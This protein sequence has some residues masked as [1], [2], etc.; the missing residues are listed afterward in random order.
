MSDIHDIVHGRWLQI[1][2]L[3]GIHLDYLVKG[4]R[5]V[6]NGPCPCCGGKDRF[7]FKIE[8]DG[9]ANFYCRHHG[10]GDGF[11]LLA[12]CF[13]WD[14]HRV[15]TEI[16]DIFG[17][18][19]QRELPKPPV[20]VQDNPQDDEKKRLSMRKAWVG[21]K[22]VVANDCV[23]WYLR[24]RGLILPVVPK[25]LRSHTHMNYYHVEKTLDKLGTY[26]CMLALVQDVEGKP[27]SLHR[28]YLQN[29]RKAKILSRSGE[30]LDVRKAMARLEGGA[31]R[32]FEPVDGMIAIAE[33]IETSL[34]VHLRTGLPVWSA[35]SAPNM[36]KMEL[37]A[38]IRKVIIYGDNDLPDEK[39]RRAGQDAANKLYERLIK[40]GREVDIRIPK[41]PGTD[42]LDEFLESQSVAA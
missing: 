8:P 27:I 2:P 15:A 10:S 6:K 7:S 42:F 35:I 1:L 39:G 33:G 12:D 16:R 37:P 9:N 29:G 25:V 11:Q 14:F 21:S 23:D 32:L 31:I 26:Q 22:A 28:T 18:N 3:L 38:A 13:G 34:A 30:V 36:Q 24:N 41:K 40:E 20:I 5:F 19:K 17:G 4:E